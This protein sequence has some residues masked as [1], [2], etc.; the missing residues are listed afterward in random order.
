MKDKEKKRLLAQLQHLDKN[1][2]GGLPSYI[3]NARKLLE[4]SRDGKNPFD[5]FVPAVP[6]GQRLDYGSTQFQEYENAG[7][8]LAIGF[9]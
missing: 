1:Y 4:D 8:T 9:Q 3:K 6:E 7:A 5:G 2:V